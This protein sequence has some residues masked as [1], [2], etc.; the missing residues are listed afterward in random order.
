MR[1]EVA[2]QSTTNGEKITAREQQK[3]SAIEAHDTQAHRR[4]ETVRTRYSV[5]SDRAWRSMGR[6]GRGVNDGEKAYHHTS[7]P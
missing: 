3:D 6:G 5:V 1:R 7:V 2:A 4:T